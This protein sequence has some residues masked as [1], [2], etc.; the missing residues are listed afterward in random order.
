MMEQTMRAHTIS[1]VS[2]T[3]KLIII[4]HI[5][6]QLLLLRLYS[7]QIELSKKKRLY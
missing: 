7:Q 3:I 2:E 1:I 6:L 4:S 5:A